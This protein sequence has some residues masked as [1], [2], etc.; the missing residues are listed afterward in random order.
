MK[1]SHEH[2]STAKFS[3]VESG[4]GPSMTTAIGPSISP[5]LKINHDQLSIDVK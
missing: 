4:D 2:R 5:N 1:V 3:Y